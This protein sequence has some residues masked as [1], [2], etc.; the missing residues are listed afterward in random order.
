[1]HAAYLAWPMHKNRLLCGL[2]TFRGAAWGHF[3]TVWCFQRL[4]L[5]WGVRWGVGRGCVVKHKN[6]KHNCICCTYTPPVFTGRCKYL[7]TGASP[8]APEVF[9]F[10]RI[11]FGATVLE[12]YG[13]TE[14]ACTITLTDP[15]DAT[16]GHVGVPTMGCEVKLD[17]IPE[18]NYRNSDTPYPRGEV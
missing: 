2:A 16:M 12:G 5:A 11:C 9:E 10:M 4:L 1:M 17:D 3:G 6:D 7:V 15:A 13:M 8:L 18:M 14:T